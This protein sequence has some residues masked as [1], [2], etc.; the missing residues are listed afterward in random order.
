MLLTARYVLPVSQAH[1]ENGAV[2]VRDGKIEDIGPAL[3]LKTRYPEE[4]VMDFGLAALLP[5]F[6]N[7]H[8]HLEYSA[9]RGIIN[10][11]PYA[12]WKTYMLEKEQQ[13]SDEDWEDSALLGA[14]EALASGITTVADMT[15]T[16]ASARA[17]SETGLR[18]IVYREVQAVLR[19]E[20]DAEIER[21][22]ADIHA[23]SDDHAD[24]RI[25]VGIAP[26]SLYACHPMVLERVAELA[27][28]YDLPLALH[29]AGSHEEYDFIR[30]GSSP[31][32]I[33]GWADGHHPDE[34]Y[35]SILPTGVSPVRYV[36]NWGILDRPGT[37]CVHCTQVD[38]DDIAILAEKEANVIYCPQPNAKLS[39]GTANV[40]E[41]LKEG[42][43]VGLGTD[44]PAAADSF[45][46]LT[47]MKFGLLLQR[48]L[49]DKNDFLTGAHMVRMATLDGAEALGIDHE[50]GSL[51]VGKKAD[52]IALDL[53]TSHQVP[54]HYPNSAIVHT[55]DSLNVLMTMIDGDIVYTEE[56]GHRYFSEAQVDHVFN[57]AEDMRIKLRS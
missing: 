10:D 3:L 36:T 33:H 17:A 50:V 53:S 48:A 14:L 42:I 15:T 51:D 49:H 25:T 32:S 29:L 56:G 24:S 12:A 57:R 23:W 5:G 27:Q 43:T 4:E 20:I 30:Y 46:M 22:E 38:A 35:P 55:T 26:Y 34:S 2:L 7:C 54:T 13:M 28:E 47:A 41:F 39:M 19:E 18:A 1:I 40:I 16:G 52:I 45:D 21:A 11:A 31:F 9:M 8:T 6:I 44:S 37:V